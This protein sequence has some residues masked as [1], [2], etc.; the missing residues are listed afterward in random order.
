MECCELEGLHSF[1]CT[2]NRYERRLVGGVEKGRVY[3][4]AF[5][6][7]GAPGYE[8]G[9]GEEGWAGEEEG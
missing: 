9:K 3:L 5:A 7:K 1:H 6:D 4:E 8:G 2:D